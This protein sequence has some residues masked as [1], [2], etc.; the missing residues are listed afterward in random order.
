MK[1]IIL[2]LTATALSLCSMAQIVNIPDAIFKAYLVGNLLINTNNDSEIQLNEAQVF[3]GEI[4]VD[5]LGVF[6]LSGIESFVN[7]TELSLW[8]NN[9]TQLNLSQNT[10][11][12]YLVCKTNSLTNLDFR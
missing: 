7:L 9:I 8:R 4:N 1:K 11:L 6:D 5:A 12:T 3:S 10:E 2:L